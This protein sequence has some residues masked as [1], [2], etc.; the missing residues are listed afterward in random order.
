[1]DLERIQGEH[2]KWAV[3]N[4]GGHT[5]TDSFFGLVEEVGELSHELLKRKQGI[6][7]TG[8]SYEKIKDACGDIAIF[9]MDFCRCEGFEL[10]EAIS[11]TWEQVK[12]RDWRK[13]PKNGIA[14]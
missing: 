6:R 13:Y 12:K 14:E 11:E 5:N 2:R 8:D 10:S 9:L 3:H 4:F 7:Q 1:M